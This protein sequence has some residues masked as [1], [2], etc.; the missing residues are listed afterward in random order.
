[1]S[2][3]YSDGSGDGN[4]LPNTNPLLGPLSNNGGPTLTMPLLDNSPAI[5]AADPTPEL[6]SPVDQRGVTRPQGPAPDIGA[7]EKN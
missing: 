2:N 4:S 7:Y 5:N 1:L 3:I 6:T